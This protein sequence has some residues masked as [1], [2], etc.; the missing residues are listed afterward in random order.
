MQEACLF[1]GDIFY[2]THV[3]LGKS[4]TGRRVSADEIFMSRMSALVT[5]GI[6]SVCLHYVLLLTRIGGFSSST[7]CTNPLDRVVTA[8][9]V[10][11][12]DAE[13]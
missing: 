11:G 13:L 5:S 8:A 2:I 10:I 12:D 9:G 3:V 6:R 7:L 4:S 1:S